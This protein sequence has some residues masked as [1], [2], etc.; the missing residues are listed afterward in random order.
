MLLHENDTAHHGCPFGHFFSVTPDDLQVDGLYRDIAVAYYPGAYRPTSIALAA[1]KLGATD[2]KLASCQGGKHR[3][4]MTAKTV[5]AANALAEV[6][7][8]AE[9]DEDDGVIDA[10]PEAGQTLSK[11]AAKVEAAVTFAAKKRGA[12]RRQSLG[13]PAEVVLP[14]LKT[15]TAA[16]TAVSYT[17]L[18][19][20][21]K[22]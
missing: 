2:G 19:V 9:D 1:K 14:A 5:A 12:A 16:Y 6:E 10:A 20:P 13:R 4:F 15:S 17:H 21:T 7:E 8:S 11:V 18:T 3:R 22:A